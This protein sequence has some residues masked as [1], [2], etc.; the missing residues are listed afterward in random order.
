[1]G[2]ANTIC[3]DKTGTLTQNRMT[4]TT[5]WNDKIAPVVPGLV[6]GYSESFAQLFTASLCCNSSAMLLPTE[7]G[8]STEI[9]FL[10][11]MLSENY[12]Y[13]QL[14]EAYPSSVRIPF[15]STRKRMS[16]VVRLQGKNTLLCKGASE[17]VLKE[18]R[19]WHNSHTGS[20][21][22]I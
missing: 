20:V 16:V 4:L 22:P 5:I 18:C 10:K 2:G 19:Y 3:S 8:S 21:Q 17:M 11:F 1:M 14:R 12:D 13:V 9:S 15:S 7:K 6:A